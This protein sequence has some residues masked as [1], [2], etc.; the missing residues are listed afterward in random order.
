[1][2]MTDFVVAFMGE[3]YCFLAGFF[4]GVLDHV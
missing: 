2:K 1:M 3:N 4:V